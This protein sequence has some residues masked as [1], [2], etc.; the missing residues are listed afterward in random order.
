LCEKYIA[1]EQYSIESPT[2]DFLLGVFTEEELSG[3][4]L[5][6]RIC[7]QRT[8]VWNYNTGKHQIS[9]LELPAEETG[10][11][12]YCKHLTRSYSSP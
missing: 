2:L 7:F 4:G 12:N 11:Q 10:S 8:T 1:L 5:D 9:D 6:L 3:I